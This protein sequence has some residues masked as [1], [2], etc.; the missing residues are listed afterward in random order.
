[1]DYIDQTQAFLLIEARSPQAE[2]ALALPG[3]DDV[4]VQ[5]DT[6]LVSGNDDLHLIF[7]PPVVLQQV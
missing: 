7:L 4:R 6:T 2:A 5:Q 1:M 3:N